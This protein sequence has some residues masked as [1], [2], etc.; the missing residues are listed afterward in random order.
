[1]P[2][3]PEGLLRV[4]FL[5]C[6]EFGPSPGR[7]T[8]FLLWPPSIRSRRSTK[9]N[10]V[11]VP[12]NRFAGHLHLALIFEPH[13]L[14]DGMV[15]TDPTEQ[16]SPLPSEGVRWVDLSSVYCE[17]ASSDSDNLW[18]PAYWAIK[19]RGYADTFGRP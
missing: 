4:P 9:I 18:V 8:A 11:Q 3:M 5:Q 17:V 19:S 14:L 15:T 10:A 7:G 6:E 1:M 2:Y 13:D 16:D 12:A